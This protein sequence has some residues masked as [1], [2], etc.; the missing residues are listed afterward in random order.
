MS[1]ENV[2]PVLTG[3]TTADSP[4]AIPPRKRSFTNSRR[5]ETISHARASEAAIRLIH[6]HFG[7]KDHA[8]ISIPLSLDDHDI[9][10]M[11]YIEQQML[12]ELDLK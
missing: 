4:L 10:I 12:K 1:T 5:T 11:D 7:Q 8:K 3:G 6:S 2:S 9:V